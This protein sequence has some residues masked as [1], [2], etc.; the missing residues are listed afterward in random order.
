M[1]LTITGSGQGA[2]PPG[3]SGRKATEARALLIAILPPGAGLCTH[4]LLPAAADRAR[5]GEEVGG[6]ERGLREGE[7]VG[8]TLAY[9]HSLGHKQ[10]GI[11]SIAGT[12]LD[13]S[14][15]R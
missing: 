13:P 7:P 5:P 14:I 15:K 9:S 6:A 3:Q 1:R 10:H 4:S 12:M 11:R 2:K 8:G